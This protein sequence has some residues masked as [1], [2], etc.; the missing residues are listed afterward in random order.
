[1][2]PSGSRR[3][4]FSLLLLRNSVQANAGAL[5]F[6]GS[7]L[8]GCRHAREMEDATSAVKVGL[9]VCDDKIGATGPASPIESHSAVAMSAPPTVKRHE[10]PPFCPVLQHS[11]LGTSCALRVLL[12]EYQAVRGRPPTLLNER[13]HPLCDAFAPVASFD[14][15]MLH[16]DLDIPP[17]VAVSQ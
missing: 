11:V 6:A 16:H 12:G 5:Q 9:N 8:Q 7:E 3:T 10:S 4:L 14:W 17:L 15:V 13:M 2:C 1:M